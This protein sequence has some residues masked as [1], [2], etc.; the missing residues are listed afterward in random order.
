M[1]FSRPSAIH[2]TFHPNPFLEPRR[3]LSPGFVGPHFRLLKE[4]GGTTKRI[5]GHSSDYSQENVGNPPSAL[6]QTAIFK[7]IAAAHQIINGSG[8][9][10]RLP[11]PESLVARRSISHGVKFGRNDLSGRY[12]VELQRCQV[13]QIP[14][15][16]GPAAVNNRLQCHRLRRINGGSEQVTGSA[17]AVISI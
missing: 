9:C 4:V 2:W 15:C 10:Q 8:G 16:A 12:L 11:G 6:K 14:S 3:G 13:H 1:L 7:W 17:S 5:K